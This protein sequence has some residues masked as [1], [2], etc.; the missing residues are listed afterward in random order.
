MSENVVETHS[1]ESRKYYTE[2]T[3]CY[4]IEQLICPAKPFFLSVL[5]CQYRLS[6]LKPIENADVILWAVPS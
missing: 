2:M 6:A 1:D 4:T 5:P 3:S